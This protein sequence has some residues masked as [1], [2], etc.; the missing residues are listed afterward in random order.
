[1][2]EHIER[3]GMFEIALQGPQTGNPFLDVTLQA[4]FKKGDRVLRAEGFYDGDGRFRIRFMPDEIGEWS[5]VTQSNVTELDGQSGRFVCV[6]PLA[7]NHG[8]VQVNN[9]HHFA[10]ADGSPYYPFA[11]TCFAWTH[12]GRELEEQ[13]LTTLATNGFNKL[14][15]C[16]FPKDCVHNKIEPECY[17][18]E[19][20]KAGENNF[21][22][23][24]PAFFQHLEQRIADLQNL[25]I[26]VD[27]IFFH[28]YDRW[29]YAAMTPEQDCRYLRY[30]IAR[31]TAFRNVWWSLA[32]EYDLMLDDKPMEQWDGFSQMVQKYD[33]YGGCLTNVSY[34]AM[35]WG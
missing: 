24:N 14:R 7:N 9:T 4:Q 13:T 35:K 34:V 27:L 20:N 17:P 10:Y 29:G 28:P 31:L 12:Q 21:T 2:T 23:F 6:A 30:V 18:F 1:M 11:I 33:P 25:G 3:W 19:R 8:P 26:E 22:R 16:I 32:S 5:Y 15:M